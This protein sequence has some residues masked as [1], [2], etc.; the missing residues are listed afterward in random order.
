MPQEILDEQEV[1]RRCDA[2]TDQFCLRAELVIWSVGCAVGIITGILLVASGI[3][4]VGVDMADGTVRIVFGLVLI[5]YCGVLMRYKYVELWKKLDNAVDSLD[6]KIVEFEWKR[7]RQ[8]LAEVASQKG[9]GDGP[10]RVG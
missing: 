8:Q 9:G 1:L 6:P 4:N 10:A 2:T 5:G 3:F 7:F